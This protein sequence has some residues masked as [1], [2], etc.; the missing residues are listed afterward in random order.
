MLSFTFNNK[1]SYKDFDILIA[2]RPSIPS[3]K[4]RVSYVEIPGRSS[5]LKFDEEAYEDITLVV[6]CSIKPS[7]DI[8]SKIDAIKGWIFNSGEADLI[9][10]FQPNRKYIAQVVNAIDFKLI[11]GIIGK[12]PLVFNCKPFKYAVENN[13]IQVKVSGTTIN[14]EGTI[15]SEPVITVYGNGNIT[16]IINNVPIVLTAIE[17]S[18]TINSTLEDCYSAAYENLNS[19][20]TGEFPRLLPGV[21]TIEW[22]GNVTQINITPNWRWI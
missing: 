4:R 22:I 2:A 12:F 15:K 8:V 11:Y 3:P 10:S 6:E 20:M 13:A 9:F 19:K 5:S 17:N 14:N 7:Q 21:N 18:I 1:D 16:L